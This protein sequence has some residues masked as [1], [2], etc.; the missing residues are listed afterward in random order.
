MT[1]PHGQVAIRDGVSVS[2]SLQGSAE[3]SGIPE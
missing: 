1:E 2:D 3:N